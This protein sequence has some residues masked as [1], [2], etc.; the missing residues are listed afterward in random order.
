MKQNYCKCCDDHDRGHEGGKFLLPKIL[1]SGREWLPRQCVELKLWGVDECAPE[2]FTLLSVEQCGQVSVQRINEHC[3][4]N[5]IVFCVKIPVVAQVKDGR[6]CIHTA[7][8]VV[9]TRTAINAC[10]CLDELWCSQVVAC[11]SVRLVNCP[12]PSCDLCF[13]AV[14]EIRVEIYL[15]RYE[16]CQSRCGNQPPPCPPPLPLYPQMP[17][18]ERY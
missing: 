7:Q 2:P 12:P 17:C 8:G 18:R 15:V 6:G 4:R 11:A 3:Q 14:L 16:P 10:G 1:A 9:E 13:A 5:Q